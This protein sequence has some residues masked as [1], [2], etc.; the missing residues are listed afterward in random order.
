MDEVECVSGG[1]APMNLD[2]LDEVSVNGTRPKR[3]A[4]GFIDFL[5]AKNGLGPE[6]TMDYF[7]AGTYSILPSLFSTR[8]WD[9]TRSDDRADYKHVADIKAGDSHLL[10]EQTS[11]DL[12]VIAPDGSLK[13]VAQG[14]SGAA[15]EARNNPQMESVKETGPIPLGTYEIGKSR[16]DSDP[17]G[18]ST[19]PLNAKWDSS[20]NRTDLLIHAENHITHDASKGCVVLDLQTREQIAKLTDAT[21]EVVRHGPAAGVYI[22]SR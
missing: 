4:V 2:D 22:Y 13:L 19:L 17:H 12:Y 20:A 7:W 21:L 18:P 3:P 8:Y 6:Q 9:M 14:Y 16:P 1:V 5:N 11:G 15:G 10:Y